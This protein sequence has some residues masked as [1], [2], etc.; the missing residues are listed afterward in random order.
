MKRFTHLLLLSTLQKWNCTILSVSN[1]DLSCKR[2]ITWSLLV[3]E[4][5]CFTM[6]MVVIFV[7]VQHIIGPNSLLGSFGR[8]LTM[9]ATRSGSPSDRIIPYTFNRRK[10]NAT[11][12]LR[13]HHHERS[14]W[15]RYLIL[16][17]SLI[18][19]L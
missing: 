10:T 1:R 3:M 17:Q 14:C 19:P 18:N 16:K 15:K 7:L 11:H 13:R 6:R 8:H 2:I 4:N 12:S 5:R 9:F